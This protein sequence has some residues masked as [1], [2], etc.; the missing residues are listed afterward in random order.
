MKFSR[1]LQCQFLEDELRAQVDEFDKILKTS[2]KYMLL[3][4]G[5]L[6]VAQFLNFNENGDM[7]LKFSNKRAIPRRRDYLYCMTL[8]QHLS[9]FHNWKDETYGDIIKDKTNQSEV[10]CLWHS[11]SKE[12][13]YTIAG[14]RGVDVLF[15]NWIKDVPGAI[16]ILGPQKPPYEYLAHLQDVVRNEM[17]DSASAVLDAEYNKIDYSPF[18]LTEKYDIPDFLLGQL[19]LSSTLILQ[20]PPGTGKTYQIAN[21]CAKLAEQGYSILV[22][23]LTNRALMEI[24]SKPS[25]QSLLKESRVFKTKITYDEAK[26]NKYL[27]LEKSVS[28]KKGCI[29]LSTFYI[30]SGVAADIT[31]DS[32]FDYVIVDEA[33]QALFP[34]IAAAKCLGSKCVF[35][36]DIN[37][38]PPVV[39]LQGSKI[40]SK[41]YKPLVEGLDTISN[42]SMVPS[43]QLSLSYRLTERA[44]KFTG[45]FYQDS[46]KSKSDLKILPQFGLPFLNEQGGPSLVL[47]DC[48]VGQLSPESEISIVGAIVKSIYDNDNNIDVAILSCMKKTVK[49]L[50]KSITTIV[51]AKEKMLIE[52]IARVQGLTT[53]IC[54]VVIPYTNYL[55]QLEKRLFNVATSRAKMHTIIVCDKD[56]LSYS[57]MNPF[58]RTYLGGLIEH[59]YYIPWDNNGIK[60][61]K[62]SDILSL[63]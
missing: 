23:A 9:D 21:V 44:V 41:G 56:I 22:T 8:H 37:Q 10:I 7:V 33:S 13:N 6:F 4:T 42:Y 1:E 29:I 60:K 32:V 31:S 57:R 35:V 47:T 46:L 43:Y 3:E 36:G 16:L 26:E 49:S 18:L 2:A 55:R 30:T 38:L 48:T 53:D 20:G 15:A 5:E 52:T 11:P 25:L 39:E 27:Q 45:I 51:G 54:I 40:I 59:S 28:P 63:P 62:G 17:S 50:Q 12:N 58:V 19:S 61:L 24:A 14:F 34:M